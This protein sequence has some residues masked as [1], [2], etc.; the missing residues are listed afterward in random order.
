MTDLFEYGQDFMI[1]NALGDG[2][3]KDTNSTEEVYES[4]SQKYRKELKKDLSEIEAEVAEDVDGEAD[5]GDYDEGKE[6]H[7]ESSGGGK[8][9]AEDEGEE[10]TSSNDMFD[11]M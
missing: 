1:G 4:F 2:K 9:A 6:T 11:E 3:P 7:D 5:E 8:K 10:F